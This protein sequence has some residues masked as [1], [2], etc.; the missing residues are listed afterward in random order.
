M[1]FSGKRPTLEICGLAAA[2]VPSPSLFANLSPKCSPIA[3]KSR[4]YSDG[5]TAF[6]NKEIER[7]LSE[8]IIEPSNSPW[9]AQVLVTTN[10][11]HTKRMVI[12]YS[13]TINKFTEID[14]YPLSHIEEILES[15]I[16]DVDPTMLFVVETDASEHSI[17]ASLSQN[18]RPVAFFSRSLSA[19]EQNHSSVE[20]EAYAIVESLKK[21]RHYLLGRHFQLIT[22]QR[23]VSFMF[24]RI[25]TSKI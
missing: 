25:K 6:M 23:S 8:G 1:P 14:A 7:L 12:D 17:A 21:W 13:Q 2:K 18:N 10:E 3:S 22:D 9:R 24:D 20:K 5:D 4:R 19:S 11:N 16:T 15:S